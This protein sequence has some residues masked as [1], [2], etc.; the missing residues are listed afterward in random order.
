MSIQ[1]IWKSS[2]PKSDGTNCAKSHYATTPALHAPEDA[3]KSHPKQDG[4]HDHVI[5]VSKQQFF[6]AATFIAIFLIIMALGF[7][8]LGS[9]TK[10]NPAE[11]KNPFLIQVTELSTSIINSH[12][13]SYESLT[14]KNANPSLQELQYQIAKMKGTIEEMNTLKDRYA[15][16][17]MPGPVRS[18]LEKSNGA[19]N[20]GNNGNLNGSSYSGPALTNKT[21]PGSA[22]AFA[23]IPDKDISATVKE[24]ALMNERLQKT[25]E[26]WLQELKLLNQMPT[27]FPI[28]N[29]AGLSSNYGSRIDPFTHLLSYHSGVDFSAP[30][31]T[32]IY[33]AGDG[34]VMRTDFDRGNG[35]YIVIEHAE[36]FTSKYAP[37]SRFL[38]RQGDQ[39]KR[40]Q[41]I[42]EVGSTG[43]STSSHLHY[44]IAYR[45]T[46]I[47]PMEALSQKP[48]QA[49]INSN[50]NQ[51]M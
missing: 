10:T 31:G 27:G 50:D 33:A 5:Q 49:A 34:K 42:A 8:H 6:I 16:L 17:A 40:G 7:Y 26:H 44:E 37:I 46:P 38:I 24:V 20:A 43:R 23:P 13:A 45:G 28:E 4:T 1:I 25:E 11:Q 18:V 21:T 36:G 32:T 22:L 39:V 9:K 48:T 41:A 15:N 14:A 12:F 51:K 2:R 29:K 30:A 19:A 47:N 3:L 35:Q